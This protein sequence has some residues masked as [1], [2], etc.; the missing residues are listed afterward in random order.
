MIQREIYRISSL[1]LAMSESLELKDSR[2]KKA[3]K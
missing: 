3:A 2:A 1:A